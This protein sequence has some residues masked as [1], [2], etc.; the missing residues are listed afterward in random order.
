MV[1]TVNQVYAAMVTSVIAAK[2]HPN[3]YVWRP[4]HANNVKNKHVTRAIYCPTRMPHTREIS[5]A[6]GTILKMI[7]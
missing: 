7:A 4:V 1:L 3:L 2:S 5:R 6:V